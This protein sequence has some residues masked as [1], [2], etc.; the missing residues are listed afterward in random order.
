MWYRL[1]GFDVIGCNEI[2]PKMMKCYIEN[3]H[4]KY[5]YLEDI[6]IF[7][8]RSDLPEELYNLDIL[9]WS[10]PCSS[11]SMAGNREEDWWKEKKFREWQELQELD[12]L[13]FD[14][15][16]VAK[17][18][19][20]KIVIAENVKGL[21]LWDA[22]KYV[23]EIYNQFD[24]AGYYMEHYLLNASKMWVPQARERVFFIWV[25]KDQTQMI[26]QKDMFN[27]WPKL[28]LEFNEKVITYGDIEDKTKTE[29][30]WRHIPAWVIPYREKIEPGRSCADVHEKWHF[31]QELKLDPE[32]PLPTL[33]AWSNSYYHYSLPRRLFDSEIIKWWS[34]PSDYNFLKQQPIYIIWMSVPPIM[35]AQVA[36]EVYS[37]LLK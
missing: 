21:L 7:K 11:F 1:A 34:F 26:Q 36:S 28:T 10:P 2:D 15:I 27:K 18:L 8:E 5:S 3:L 19:Q 12:T 35:M 31:F 14:F 20:P 4:P 17:K 32:K 13:F 25:R 23:Q 24:E 29:Q 30:E 22:W 33:R 9:D 6:R 37:Q 16:D